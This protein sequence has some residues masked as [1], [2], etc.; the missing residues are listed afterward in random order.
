M[1]E[2]K[3]DRRPLHIQAQQHLLKLIED[4]AYKPGQQLPS[5][6]NLAAQLGISRP[7]L[8][9]ALFNLEQEGVIVRKHGVG[10]FVAPAYGDRLAS[11]LER[12]ESILAL[13]DRQGMSTQM[14]RLSVEQIP[15]DD[16]L[17][18]RLELA[19]G[20]PLTRVRRTIAVDGRSAA[21]LVDFMPA[22]VLPPEALGKSFNGSVLDLLVRRNGIR[23]R[24]ALAEVTA[25]NADALLAE[26]L[27][28][29]LGHAV[30]LL[31]ETLFTEEL[32]PIEFSR[33]YFLP[34]FFDFHILRR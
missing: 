28:V 17:A 21:Y 9:E 27:E 12:L 8:R 2:L 33:N 22:A 20:T 24:E 14:L 6:S 10:T 19:P 31:S 26:H 34:D 25:I 23:V 32:A 11:G 16:R 18:E 29:R 4:G 5:E 13:A 30:L 3:L 15:A 7:T 1:Y